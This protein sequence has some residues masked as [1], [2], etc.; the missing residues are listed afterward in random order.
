MVTMGKAE[1]A[2]R[3]GVCRDG[4][5]GGNLLDAALAEARETAY[6]RAAEICVG[7]AHGDCNVAEQCAEFILAEIKNGPG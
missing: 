2:L 1:K 7:E 6:R 5:G 3:M 4:T